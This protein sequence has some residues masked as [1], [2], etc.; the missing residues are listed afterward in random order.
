MAEG[1]VLVTGFERGRLRVIDPREGERWI[2]LAEL[3]Q[4]QA[5]CRAVTF[6]RRPTTA[7]KRFDITYF[8]PIPAALP[9]LTGAGICASLFIQIFSLAQPSDNSADHRQGDWTAEFQYPLFSGCAVN[10]MQCDL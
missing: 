2:D 3:E 10:W 7:T 5:I 8:F 4:D 1:L 9:P 6:S